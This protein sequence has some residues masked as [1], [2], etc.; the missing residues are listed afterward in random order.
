MSITN[1]IPSGV[2]SR[3]RNSITIAGASVTGTATI[4]AVDTT[5]S[6]L[7]FLGCS[8]SVDATGLATLALTNSTTVTAT[9]QATGQNT[10]VA[11]EVVEWW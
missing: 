4:S 11:F 6:E 8:V 10:V 5:K 1:T 9:R 7:R 3:Q 2:K